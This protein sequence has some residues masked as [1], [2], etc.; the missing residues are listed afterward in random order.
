[1]FTLI[2]RYSV[3]NLT[4]LCGCSESTICTQRVQVMANLMAKSAYYSVNLSSKAFSNLLCK[5][6]RCYGRLEG[7]G[8]ALL[9]VYASVSHGA[10][11]QMSALCADA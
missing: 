6:I 8:H 11:V 7:R 4:R 5:S 10:I 1:M 9:G 2:S 3:Q